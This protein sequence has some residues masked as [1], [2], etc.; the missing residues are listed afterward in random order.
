MSRSTK[1]SDPF[2]GSSLSLNFGNECDQFCDVDLAYKAEGMSSILIAVLQLSWVAA[3]MEYREYHDLIGFDDEMN[4]VREPAQNG[5]SS[6][7]ADFRKDFGI[8]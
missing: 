5:S 3:C 1:E 7:P 8:A 4:G 6:L 2:D